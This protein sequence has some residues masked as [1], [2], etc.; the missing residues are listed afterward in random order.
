MQKLVD[1]ISTFFE[2]RA[3]GV[4]DWWGRRLG[5]SSSK[6]RMYFIYISFITL[7]SPLIIYLFMAFWLEHK[8]FF[9]SR[10]K[11]TIWDL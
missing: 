4:C 5:I 2:K 3:F 1:R 6:V 11:N 10:P 7:G 9:K 8:D